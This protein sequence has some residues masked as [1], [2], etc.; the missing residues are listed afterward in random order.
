MTYKAKPEHEVWT[1][2]RCYITELLNCDSQPEVS[3][4]RARVEPG[5]T[6]QLHTLSVYE[7]YVIETGQ[8]LMRVGI[9]PVFAVGP[10]D[11]IAIPKHLAQQITNDGQEDL[12]FLC[13]C[14]PKFSQE[15]YNS[16]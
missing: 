16:P 13:I 5:V 10:G 1:N 7:W 12:C 11:T 15:H 8:G 3:I 2:E 9:E 6:T 14:T 4:A